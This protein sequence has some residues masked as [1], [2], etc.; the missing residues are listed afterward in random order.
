MFVVPK[1]ISFS[2]LALRDKRRVVLWA[3]AGFQFTPAALLNPALM[4]R[5]RRFGSQPP[6]V[7]RQFF[8]KVSALPRDCSKSISELVTVNA[9]GGLAKALFAISARCNQI[10]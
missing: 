6:H 3:N 4:P 5:G 7:L 2:S 1:S 10:I 9:F 8:G